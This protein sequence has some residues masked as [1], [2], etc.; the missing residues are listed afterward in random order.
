MYFLTV[1]YCH[2]DIDRIVYNIATKIFYDIAITVYDIPIMIV[3]HNIMMIC[4]YI[5][6]M[7]KSQRNNKENFYLYYLKAKIIFK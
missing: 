7:C 2:N 3:C 6:V 4:Y 5:T 1:I